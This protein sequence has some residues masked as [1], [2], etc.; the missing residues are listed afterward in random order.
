MDMFNKIILITGISLVFTALSVF[1]FIQH[2][3]S[4]RPITPIVY[5]K[6]AMLLELWEDY[7][8]KNIEPSSNRTLD[9]SQDNI[10]T[11]EGQSYTMLRA[12]WMDDKDTF[13]KSWQFTKDNMQRSSDHLLSWKFGQRTDKTY[14]VLTDIG[15]QNTASDADIDT[16]LSL[17]MAYKRWNESSYLYQAE[18]MISSIWEQEVVIIN[19]KPVLVAND[20]EKND[21]HSVVV[22]PSYFSPYS[23]KLFS[24]VDSTKHDW[25]SLVD[26]SY[27]LLASLSKDK[28]G[29][30]SSSGL[31]P[32][33]IKIN[34][35]T[36]AFIPNAGSNLDTN[37]GY[38]IL[39]T[40]SFLS[41]KWSADKTVK[42]VY[43][44]DGGF[45]E[46]YESPATYGGVIGY[47]D[48]VSTTT[49][50]E[51]YA[52]KLEALY[53]PDRQGWTV[54]LS[55]YDDNWAWFGIALTQKALPNLATSE[56]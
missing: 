19:G 28:L 4:S 38:D 46:S 50:D 55:Y 43:K 10:T 51:V 53:S 34:R 17:L 42:A 33:W 16:A 18:Q 39:Q 48:V 37:Y 3:G 35:A 31:P 56:Y 7:K 23:F 21:T 30:S 11:S 52:Q 47:F 1:V 2:A 49:A 8:S 14:G 24:K 26:N 20:L 54:P 41:D 40:F 44:H 12:V 36:G 6:S 13:D 9:K 32:N 25:N 22:N 29:S 45:V 27:T 15:G 5:A